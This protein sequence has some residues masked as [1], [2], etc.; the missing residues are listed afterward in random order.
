V[1]P[2]EDQ[3]SVQFYD[4]LALHRLLAPLVTGPELATFVEGELGDVISYDEA[5]SADL[6][7]TLDAFLQTNGNKQSMGRVLHLRRRSVYYR[8]ERIEQLLGGSLDTPD[9]RAR[10]YL[11]LRARE[12]LDEGAPSEAV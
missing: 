7:K 1:V 5:H 3:A 2:A 4:E 9:L 10:L 12:L 11:A 6:L 8:L